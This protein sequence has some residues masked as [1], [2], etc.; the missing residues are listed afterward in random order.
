MFE[1]LGLDGWTP[2]SA[3]VVFGLAIGLTFGF[4]AQ[5]SRFCLRRGLTGDQHERS[6]ALGTW[7]IALAVAIAGTAALTAFELVSF[8]EHRFH[9]SSLPMGAIIIGGLLFGAGMFLARGCASRLTVLAGT[10]NL[11]AATVIIIFAITAHATLK[12]AIAPARVWL[13]S[14]TIDLNGFATLGALPGGTLLWSAIAVAVL[15]AIA[16]RSGASLRDLALGGLI[17]VLI[18]I[19]WLGTG[20]VLADEF[21]PITHES[22][23]FTSAASETLFWWVAGTAIAPGFG[24]GLFGGVL[25]GSLLAA[26]LFSEFRWVGF[27]ANT[28]I[29]TGRYLTGGILMGVGGVLAGGCT[30]GA[31]LSGVATLSVSAI[32]ALASIATGALVAQSIALHT[33]AVAL[34]LPAE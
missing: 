5:R 17:G 19:G 7:L 21:D 3:S 10:G 12:G 14:F 27:T 30:I 15:L 29:T 18:P 2:V 20:F 16:A 4:L 11:R 22:L 23:A 25:A 34:P 1:Q 28:E 31:G 32:L 26:L 24:V 33:P 6:A 8:A 13:G 9:A